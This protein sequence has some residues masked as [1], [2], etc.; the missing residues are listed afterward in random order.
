MKESGKRMKLLLD[1]FL[2][3]APVKLF[4]NL[5]LRY[6]LLLSYILVT[7]LPVTAIGVF[8]YTSNLSYIKKQNVITMSNSQQQYKINILSRLDSYMKTADT[9]YYNRM[10]QNYLVASE[11]DYYNEFDFITSY[12]TPVINSLLEATGKGILLDIIRYTSKKHEVINKFYTTQSVVP[13]GVD[14]L[15]AGFKSF[16]LYNID[17][18]ENEDWLKKARND[19]IDSVW[20][21]V[22]DDEKFHNISLLKPIVSL[23]DVSQKKIGLLKITVKLKSIID[24]GKTGDI[25]NREFHL[26]FDQSNHLL[27]HEEGRESFFSQYY[28]QIYP[29][30]TSSKNSDSLYLKDY[31]IIKETVESTGWK[32]LSV[33]PIKNLNE[34]A[35]NVRNATIL[36]CL[37]ALIVLMIITYILSTSFSKRIIK[38]SDSMN[39]FQNGEFGMV[40]TDTHNDEI[41]YLA[42]SFN[43]TVCQIK[44]LIQDNYQANIDKREAQLK[45]LQ[46]Q[47]NPHFLYNSLSSISRLANRKDSDSINKMVRALTTF[48]R[49]TLNKGKDIIRISDELDQVKAYI[50]VYQVRK[51]DDFTVVFDIEECVLGY[52]TIKVILQPFVENVL[53]HAIDIRETPLTLLISAKMHEDAIVFQIIDDGIGMR[54]EKVESALLTASVMTKGYGIKNVDDRIKLQFGNEYGVQIFSRLGIGTVATLR[55][56]KF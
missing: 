42:R 1:T 41:G 27:S 28:P 31:V 5:K 25:G 40:I 51:G 7:V 13:D 50:D 16:N 26:V 4:Y 3:Q 24:E 14:Y 29:F 30:L 53:E 33:N 21:Q 2:F 47:I 11:Q 45:A 54:P 46:A 37:I 18:L 17:R 55:I 56:P 23:E 52:Q 49:M 32:M 35:K 10:I 19:D 39:Q 38:I 48:Y 20:Q 6:K 44:N 12:L 8:S 43:E 9:I 34:N 22:G 36:Y 15:A